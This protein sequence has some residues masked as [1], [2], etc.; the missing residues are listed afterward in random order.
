MTEITQ[1]GATPLA[2]ASL[3]LA[4]VMISPALVGGMWLHEFKTR[5]EDVTYNHPTRATVIQTLGG[6]F[7]DDF[8]EGI[9]EITVQGHTGWRYAPNINGGLGSMDGAQ[10]MYNLRYY[11]FQVFHEQRM[12]AAQAGL[13]PD[14]VVNLY[15][16]DALHFCAYRVYPVALQVRKNKSRPLLYQYQLRLTGLEKILGEL[17][18]INLLWINNT[19]IGAL[20][21]TLT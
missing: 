9:V 2:Q 8:G 12:L 6:A 15:W 16:I 20:A 17:D 1:Y 10:Q 5:P 18:Q 11:F 13:A 21:G 4:L 19:L 14:D 3:P 7:V